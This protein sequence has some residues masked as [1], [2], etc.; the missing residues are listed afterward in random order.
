MILPSED[1]GSYISQ[2]PFR[3][4]RRMRGMDGALSLDAQPSQ[5]LEQ[6]K[7]MPPIFGLNIF[8]LTRAGATTWAETLHNSQDLQDQPLLTIQRYGLGRCAV[9]ATGE[10]WYWHMNTTEEPS[11][12]ARLWRQMLRIL[13]NEVP[14]PIELRS[15]QDTYPSGNPVPLDLLVRNQEFHRGGHDLRFCCRNRPG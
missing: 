7:Q 5:S 11:P 8:S 13:V 6:W 12:H 9:L 10:T 14:D 4:S 1:D 15:V 2:T 3:F